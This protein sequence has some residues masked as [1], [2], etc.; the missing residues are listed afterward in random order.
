MKRRVFK[1]NDYLKLK[2]KKD[3]T[4]IYVK[5]RKFIQCKHLLLDLELGKLYDE[6]DSIDE[7]AEHLSNEMEY[8]HGIIS[9][10]E[11]FWG[12]CSNLQAWYEYGYNTRLLHS[13]LAFPLLKK[14]T[15]AGDPQA[16]R[17]LKRR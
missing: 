3:K 7:A 13:N 4:I 10:E 1:I 5:N 16:K 15:K 8:D 6:I 11:E 12:H 9:P 17:S 2:L 14:L